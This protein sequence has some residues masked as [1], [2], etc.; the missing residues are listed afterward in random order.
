ME[1]DCISFCLAP[2]NTSSSLTKTTA[3]TTATFNNINLRNLLGDIYNKHS[4]Y[5]L[6]VSGVF[7]R[8]VSYIGNYAGGVD[9]V[10]SG[11]SFVNNYDTSQLICSAKDCA[12]VSTNTAMNVT[13]VYSNANGV[14]FE[15]GS[16]DFISFTIKAINTDM[17]T[18]NGYDFENILFK[19]TCIPDAVPEKPISFYNRNGVKLVLSYVQ[20]IALTSYRTAYQFNVNMR[21]VLGSLYDKYD[22]FVLAT[23]RLGIQ[24]DSTSASGY[25]YSSAGYGTTIMMSGLNF[26]NNFE[27]PSKY[28]YNTTATSYS[29][30]AMSK[31]CKQTPVSVGYINMLASSSVAP[32]PAVYQYGGPFNQNTINKFEKQDYAEI[33]L[34]TSFQASGDLDQGAINGTPFPLVVAE[35]MIYGI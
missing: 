4:L 34:Y 26:I 31:Y 35:F 10:I 18:F 11:L 24:S 8:T 22:R 7:Q 5:R 9:I 12:I 27:Y 30:S 20:G 28:N 16:S 14:T 32:L 21:D 6:N 29:G 23:T 2:S 17:T 3:T 33:I 15:K 25:M 1:I 13:P 19:I